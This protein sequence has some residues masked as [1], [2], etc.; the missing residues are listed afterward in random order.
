MVRKKGVDRKKQMDT[1]GMRI[2]LS[3]DEKDV[4]DWSIEMSGSL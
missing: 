2:R 4:R 1:R 3:Y